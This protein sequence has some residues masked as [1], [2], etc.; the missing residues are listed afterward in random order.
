MFWLRDGLR[1]LQRPRI[2]ACGYAIVPSHDETSAGQVAIVVDEENRASYTGLV[3]CGSIWECPTCQMT[4]K[5]AR[6]KEIAYCVDSHGIDRCAMLTLTIR[7][8]FT[9]GHDLAHVR[10]ALANVWR[11]VIRGAPW[12]RFKRQLGI[13]HMVRAVDLTYSEANGWHPHLHVLLFLN[14]PPSDDELRLQTD[15]RGRKVWRWF[16]RGATGESWLRDRW[17]D[18]V[19][20]ELGAYA[21]PDDEHGCTL[22][23][24]YKADYIAKLGLELSDP[25]LKRGRDKGRTPLQIAC[26]FCSHGR[27]RDAGL[28]QAYCAAMKGARFLTWSQGCKK[29][30]G[31]AVRSDLD[32][33]QDEQDQTNTR[34]VATVNAYAWQSLRGRVIQTDTGP[35]SAMYWV[36]E[37]AETG[38]AAALQRA[39][40]LVATGEIGGDAVDAPGDLSRSQKQGAHAQVT[41]GGSC[42]TADRPA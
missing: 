11:R 35:C 4:I 2:R 33:A 20:A 32:L 39:L 26:D 41:R 18:M 23:P 36:L 1:C 31:I 30:F 21:R 29:A 9:I 37:Q 5:A 12:K 17:A 14:E 3:H 10:K 15:G 34:T 22:G 24:C 38:G 40:L 7:H 28:W 13:W 42:L 19:E 25:G 6:A 16:P 8:D 27:R